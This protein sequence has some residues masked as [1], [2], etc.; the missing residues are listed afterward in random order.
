[1]A[2]A[3]TRPPDGPQRLQRV[4]GPP[5]DR[6]PAAAGR[7]G[8]PRR[9]RDRQQRHPRRHARP[10]RRGVAAGRAAG[11][12]PRAEGRRRTMEPDRIWAPPDEPGIEPLPLLIGSDDILADSLVIAL[13]EGT[14]YRTHYTVRC[15]G[16]WR[17]REVRVSL[18]ESP[19]PPVALLSD[20]AGHWKTP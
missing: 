7:E 1:R 5:A 20:G 17:V 10:G 16:G 3:A 18:L 11:G 2:G 4:R 13:H 8:R 9:R 6:R 14:P 15:D 12:G 19:V